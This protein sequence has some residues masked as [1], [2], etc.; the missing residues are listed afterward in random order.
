MAVRR[1]HT[2]LVSGRDHGANG[3]HEFPS[4]QPLG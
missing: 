3:A 2:T 1:R 4:V